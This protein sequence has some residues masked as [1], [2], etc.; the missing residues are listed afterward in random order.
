MGLAIRHA[1]G[2]QIASILDMLD[3]R[4]YRSER[5]L[6]LPL[7]TPSPASARESDEALSITQDLLRRF[8]PRLVGFGIVDPRDPGDR[9]AEA[10]TN[11]VVRAGA[12]AERKNTSEP[13]KT[14]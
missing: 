7:F 8:N 2:A 6:R 13:F 3:L 10:Q 9:S 11:A 4:R 1:D 5:G 14:S 12:V